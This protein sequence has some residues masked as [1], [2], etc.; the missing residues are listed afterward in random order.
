MYNY[1]KKEYQNP[2]L[3]K[4][5]GNSKNSSFLRVASFGWHRANRVKERSVFRNCQQNPNLKKVLAIPKKSRFLR[6][7][8][9]GCLR[10]NRIEKRSVFRNCQQT[11]NLK[12][13]LA[14]PKNQA[15]CIR[16]SSC[17]PYQEAIRF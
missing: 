15:S 8:S 10:A 2:N 11:P 9:S 1:N 4:S 13:V 17:E 5:V 6:A 14:I 3:K 7:A 16:R 12:K